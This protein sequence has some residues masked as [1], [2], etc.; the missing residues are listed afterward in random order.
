[1]TAALTAR[2]EF[3]AQPPLVSKSAKTYPTGFSTIQCFDFD[4][5]DNAG[6][7]RAHHIQKFGDALKADGFVAVKVTPVMQELIKDVYRVQEEFFKLPLEEKDRYYF[8]EKL[9]QTGYVPEKR[10]TAAG[11]KFSDIKELVM[12]DPGFTT[13][14]NAEFE[15]VV[16]AYREAASEMAAKAMSFIAD[17]LGENLE[18]PE[19]IKSGPSHLLRCLYYRALTPLDPIGALR[20]DAHGDLNC[21]TLLPTATAPGL[22]LQEKDGITWRDVTVPEGYMI[23]NSG[24]QLWRKTSG[25]FREVIH[26][27]VNPDADQNVERMSVV[28][29][30]SWSSPFDLSPL[31]SCVKK[32]TRGMSPEDKKNYL[33]QFPKVT[34]A[35]N[36]EARVIELGYNTNPTEE[37]LNELV[38]RGLVLDPPAELV[39]KYPKVFNPSEDPLDQV[40]TLREALNKA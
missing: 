34:V 28:F 17:Y 31:E 14:P 9:G 27:V 29:F 32:M 6:F 39:K 33:A 16:K 4:A 12:V 40:L 5:I 8:P 38:K 2:T 24:R 20:A 36:L 1:M 10:E 11:K 37:R 19:T 13:W 23:I 22:Q 30:G 7:D 15:R 21:I 35:E 25:M 18:D 26:R 3:V